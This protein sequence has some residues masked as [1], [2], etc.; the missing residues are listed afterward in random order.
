[1]MTTKKGANQ[2]EQRGNVM[3]SKTRKHLEHPGHPDH[4]PECSPEDSN[5]LV[6]IPKIPP[7][8]RLP[9]RP[10]PYKPKRTDCCD[11]LLAILKTI[12]TIDPKF[13]HKPKTPIRRKVDCLC[14]TLPV[15]DAVADP[16]PHPR[17]LLGK[18]GH[19]EL[20]RGGAVPVSIS[21]KESMRENG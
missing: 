16:F 21:V 1:M 14:A 11:Q 4:W 13:L 15:R 3:E 2:N 20:F 19:R 7:S 18:K 6:R 17:A 10:E 8:G 12:G 9:K 5:P